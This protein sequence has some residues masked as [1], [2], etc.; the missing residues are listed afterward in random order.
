[1]AAALPIIAAHH[2]GSQIRWQTSCGKEAMLNTKT[3]RRFRRGRQAEREAGRNEERKE[4]NVN[5]LNFT[6]KIYPATNHYN[7]VIRRLKKTGKR[8]I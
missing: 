8:S 5:R 7:K 1:M 4:R 6:E 3:K 2:H